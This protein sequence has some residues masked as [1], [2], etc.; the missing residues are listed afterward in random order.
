MIREITFLKL[1]EPMFAPGAGFGQLGDIFPSNT[2]TLKGFK[3]SYS[4]EDQ[5]I[6]IAYNGKE[7][8]TSVSN[9]VTMVFAA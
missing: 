9:V 5:L 1:K 6:T 2:K 4:S 3:M 8:A 7:L